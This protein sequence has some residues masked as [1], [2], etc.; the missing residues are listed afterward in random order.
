M[1]QHPTAQRIMENSTQLNGIPVLPASIKNIP[2][3]R[4]INARE[5]A[6]SD[7]LWRKRIAREYV[8]NYKR[9]HSAALRQVQDIFVAEDIVSGLL[10]EALKW[11]LHKRRATNLYAYLLEAVRHRSINVVVRKRVFYDT[12]ALSIISQETCSETS[13]IEYDLE[14]ER[15]LLCLPP[16][17]A[18]AYRLYYAGYTHEEIAAAMNLV[19]VAASR[20]LIYN[21]RKKLRELYLEWNP[22]DPDDGGGNGGSD[23]RVKRSRKESKHID[24]RSLSTSTNDILMYAAGTLSDA[25]RKQAILHWLLFNS[26]AID[27]VSILRRLEKNLKRNVVENNRTLIEKNEIKVLSWFREE[28]T[29]VIHG[30]YCSSI[31][32]G[33]KSPETNR[34]TIISYKPAPDQIC[35]PFSNGN[36]GLAFHYQAGNSAIFSDIGYNPKFLVLLHDDY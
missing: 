28:P 32:F 16:R 25:H 23:L 5:L 33:A 17:Q 19:T 29:F 12:E 24:S 27:L 18:E 3:F 34:K 2:V 8:V 6:W 30:K 4:Y 10:A 35:L 14:L 15:L 1:K 22:T 9:L 36:A 31:S 26:Q 20:M 13:H 7:L 21:A 11:P